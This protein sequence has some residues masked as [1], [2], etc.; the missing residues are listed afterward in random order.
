MATN[1][2]YKIQKT[3]S[4]IYRAFNNASA[5][6]SLSFYRYDFDSIKYNDYQ[7]GIVC[8]GPVSENTKGII[9]FYSKS[10][11]RSIIILS[12]WCGDD[13]TFEIPKNVKIIYSKKPVNSG[14]MNLYLQRNS[15]LSGLQYLTK[16][17]K[18]DSRVLKIRTDYAPTRPQQLFDYIYSLENL[19]DSFRDR[20]WVPDINTFSNVAFSIGDM[21]QVGALSDLENIWLNI[22]DDIESFSVEG[23]FKRSK[24]QQDINAINSLDLPEKVVGRS[25]AT[26]RGVQHDQNGYEEL[27]RDHIGVIDADAVGF[28]FDK[29][30][31]HRDGRSASHTAKEYVN[32]LEWFIKCSI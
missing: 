27:L 31:W 18:A 16:Y 10:F 25:F 19:S 22:A 12:T 11:P 4:Y 8:Q 17:L 30:N 14:P 6:Y 3:L 1:L 21:F 13:I 24:N 26:L 32:Q 15:T 29:Y 9:D 23:Y 20:L 28:S 2:K 7:I 5:Q